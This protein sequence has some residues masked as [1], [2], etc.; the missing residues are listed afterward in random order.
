MSA[1]TRKRPACYIMGRGSSRW[2]A[3]LLP[4]PQR[5]D[6]YEQEHR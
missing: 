2:E 1:V 3:V 5:K 4:A 6:Q